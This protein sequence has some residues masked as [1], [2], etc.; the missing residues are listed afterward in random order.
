M[1]DATSPAR[2]AL[3]APGRP[4]AVVTP[5]GK[6]LPWRVVNGV[7]VGH[8]VAQPIQH[9][10]APGLR[11]ECWGYSMFTVL[12]VRNDPD[13]ADAQ[14]WYQYPAGSVAASADPARMAADG[15]DAR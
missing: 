2:A 14:G 1:A 12:K 4:P 8:L 7:K 9:E 5:N 10:F 3:V 15:I 6:S 13:A 11:A